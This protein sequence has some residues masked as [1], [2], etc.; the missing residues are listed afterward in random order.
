MEQR[1]TSL[2]DLAEIIH[3]APE[4][5]LDRFHSNGSRLGEV[6]FETLKANYDGNEVSIY[7][8]WSGKLEDFEGFRNEGL[9]SISGSKKGKTE[10]TYMFYEPPVSDI[11]LIAR[12]RYLSQIKT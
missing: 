10:S 8:Q 12:G 4:F 5:K 7:W 6:S 3:N 9:H 2:E 1:E 11:A